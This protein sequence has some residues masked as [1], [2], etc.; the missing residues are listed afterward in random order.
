MDELR[1][2]LVQCLNDELIQIIM[3]NTK[4]SSLASKMKVRPVLIKDELLF[5]ETIYRGTQVFHENFF[6]TAK[7]R[8][9][10][11]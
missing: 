9:V 2:L 10:A 7:F 3:S 11:Y 8:K 6:A 1:E 4:D 5:Q